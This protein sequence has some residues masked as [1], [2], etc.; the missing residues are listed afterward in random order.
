MLPAAWPRPPASASWG[1]ASGCCPASGGCACRCPGPA[2][3]TA[4]PGRSPPATASCSSTPACTS[5]ARSPTSSARWSRSTCELEHVRLLVCTHA[6]SDHY[7]QA[8]PIVERAGC[9]LWMHPN[10]EHMTRAA[11]GPRRG[12]GAAPRGRAPE[13][14]ARGAAARATPRRA[15]A[16]ARASPRSSSPT[17][18]LVPGVEIDTDLGTWHV[19]ET[20]GPRALARL[21]LP[22]R[23]PA[24][25]LRR[26]PARPRLA[27]LRLRLDA[28]PGRRV[29]RLAGR[30]S[31][32]STRA[33]A[34]AGHG[35]PF[36]DVR[37]AR[38]GQPGARRTS[39]S[40][41]SA[42]AIAGGPAHR[43]RGR[44]RRLRRAA[45]AR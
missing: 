18:T 13:R 27:L 1:A 41:P 42:A 19:H 5:R 20:P 31:S 10:H 28:G 15:R 8:A 16:R 34:C 36:T 11:R 25:D 37:G 24:A 33:C 32:G 39:A 35:R 26:P 9:E 2:C 7:G 6:H 40:T 23:A 45:D 22:A 14:R 4:T 3:R 44:P 43:L 38:R 12:A 21:P 17:A 29:P 30:R